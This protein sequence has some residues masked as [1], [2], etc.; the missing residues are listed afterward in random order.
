MQVSRI[1]DGEKGSLV[2]IK[3]KI[4]IYLYIVRTYKKELLFYLIIL[5]FYNSKLLQLKLNL[6]ISDLL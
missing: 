6:S 3:R 1:Y 4:F 2:A 5:L